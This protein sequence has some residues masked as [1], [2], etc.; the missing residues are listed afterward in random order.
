MPRSPVRT[1]AL[2]FVVTGL[3]AS[4]SPVSA[5]PGASAEI[6]SDHA[7]GVRV[8]DGQGELF[9]RRT[10]E[11]F[12][13]RGANYVYRETDGPARP[14]EVFRV[15]AYDGERVRRDLGRLAEHGYN[16]IRAFFDHCDPQDVGCIGRV[17]G[18]GLNPDY[19]ANVADLL[20]AAREQGIHVLLTSNDLPD[21]GGYSAQANAV[22]GPHFA[23]YRNAF[24]LT[25]DAID[26]TR[27]YWRDIITGLS[28][29]A[30]PLG[31]VLAWELVNEQW[32]FE[33]QPPLSLTAGV[34]ETTTGRYD[35]ADPA[36]KRA[37]VA[38]G[39]VHY[40]RELKA[41]ILT[42]DPG[43]LVTMGF[44]GPRAAPGWY[45]DPASALARADLDFL[46]FHAYPGG[47]DLATVARSLGV[48]E[49]PERPVILGEF[50]SFRHSAPDIET[51]A[52]AV[53]EWQTESCRLGLD[54]WLYWTYLGAEPSVRDATW[55]L[56]D[57]DGTCCGCSRRTR[58]RIP[59]DRSAGSIEQ[60]PRRHG[61]SVQELRARAPARAI[62]DD[63]AT[64]WVA[65]ARPDQWI[66]L[67][68]RRSITLAELQLVVSQDP[69]GR[70]THV[71]EVRRDGQR[72]F[73]TLGRL[74]G[75]TADGDVL[76]FRPRRAAR[77]VVS[78]RVRT[79][80]S[81]SWVAWREI[82]AFGTR[83]PRPTAPR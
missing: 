53:A 24:Y 29:H 59:A 79:V 50:G 55:G 7:I 46:D 71:I 38:D 4:G 15:G 67:D 43:A 42:H 40:V 83:R 18:P 35:M 31:Q 76:V 28:E 17:D 47:I 26:A 70:T 14:P 72:G 51:A 58:I 81:P 54:G 3:C 48:A 74:R 75:R 25:P 8:V 32:I 13:V 44:F 60:G 27:R 80:E 19:L 22:A 68:L 56:V 5:A 61:A 20:L 36:R 77:D 65:G 39:I 12:V 49:H 37:M 57:E 82:R 41:E 16:T 1:L 62:D 9:D 11:R 64:T 30:A 52:A 33:D 63:L 45:T 23:G 66:R 78:I 2:A 69:P 6:A 73:R 10:G 34:V 21:H